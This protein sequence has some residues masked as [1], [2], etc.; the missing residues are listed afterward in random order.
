MTALRL[1]LAALLGACAF[2]GAVWWFGPGPLAPAPSP[3]PSPEPRAAMAPAPAA[4]PRARASP[5]PLQAKAR[6]PEAPAPSESPALPEPPEPPEAEPPSSGTGDLAIYEQAPMSAVPHRVVRAWGLTD[7]RKNRG[8]VG[9]S[10]I[11][12][13]GMPE[14]Q[15]VQLG[16][17]LLE[18]HRG[19]K[20]VAVRVFDSEEAATYDRHIDGGVMAEAHLV[21]RVVSDPKSGV[22]GMYVHGKWMEP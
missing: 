12:E 9:A 11:V 17:D 16:R 18:Y 14:S 10:L 7:D 20:I 5:S 4:P 6:L 21:A 19:A 8:L 3:V 13:P 2:A 22:R 15:L 1:L